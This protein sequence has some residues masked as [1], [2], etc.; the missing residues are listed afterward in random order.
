MS[1]DTARARGR[2]ALAQKRQQLVRGSKAEL[3]PRI[4]LF[5]AAF[6]LPCFRLCVWAELED[7]RPSHTHK[8]K[9]R[10]REPSDVKVPWNPAFNFR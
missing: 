10:T 5:D 9:L 7:E 3:A 2:G 8:N 4:H 6:E 1:V